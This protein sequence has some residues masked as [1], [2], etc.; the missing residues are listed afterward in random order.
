MSVTIFGNYY[1]S[2]AT[3][4]KEMQN[5]RINLGKMLRFS[6][7]NFIILLNSIKNRKIIDV[8]TT[9]KYNPCI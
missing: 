5:L 2:S 7:K 8:L 9:L 3:I 4:A 1:I 6:I